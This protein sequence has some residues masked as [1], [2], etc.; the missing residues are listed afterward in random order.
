MKEKIKELREQGLTVKQISTTLGCAISTVSYH[1]ERL[2]MKTEYNTNLKN[3]EELIK[4]YQTNKSIKKAAKHFNVSYETAKKICKDFGVEIVRKRELSKSEAVIQWRQR[5]KLKLIDY[6]GGC[7]QCCGYNKS[8]RALAFHH[9]KPL[10]KDFQ[11]SASSKSFETLK[12]EVDKCVLV[13][14][15]CHSEIHDEIDATGE[16]E[17]VNNILIKNGN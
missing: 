15:N 17:I 8:V 11:I 5:T 3:P 14:H 12:V 4:H 6:K 13:C 2:G 10:E 7:C 16:S 9:I 1:L